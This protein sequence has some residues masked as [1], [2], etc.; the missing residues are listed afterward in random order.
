VTT[1][2]TMRSRLKYNRPSVRKLARPPKQRTAPGQAF[3]SANLG[4]ALAMQ[5]CASCGDSQYPA[6][7]LC[8]NCLADKLVWRECDTRGSLLSSIELHHSL[9]EFFKRKIAHAPWPI[10]SIEMANGCIVF[11]HLALPTFG[12]TTVDSLEAGQPVRVF[13]H[14]DAS[15]SAVLVAVSADTDIST[16]QQRQDIA[17]ALG[18]LEP[19][20]KAGGI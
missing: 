1:S 14:T 20:I 9:W 13:S 19:A 3:T 17:A 2:P 11:A 4:C 16:A 6:R 10:A 18:L 5:V 7:E 15:L 8:Q 12:D